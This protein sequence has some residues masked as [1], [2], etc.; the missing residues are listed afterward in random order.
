MGAA[1]LSFEYE[2]DSFPVRNN[3]V[4]TDDHEGLMEWMIKTSF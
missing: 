2:I 3:A 4:P 1:A